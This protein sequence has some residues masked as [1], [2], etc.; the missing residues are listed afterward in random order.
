MVYRIQ[1]RDGAQWRSLGLDCLDRGEVRA[2][3]AM[4]PHGA[5]YRVRLVSMEG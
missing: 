2:A 5:V 3:L 4:V 1:V